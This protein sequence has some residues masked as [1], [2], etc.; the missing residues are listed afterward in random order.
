MG[1]VLH[2]GPE[3]SIVHRFRPRAA[4]WLAVDIDPDHP[5]TDRTMS[6][7][8]LELPDGACSLVLCSHVLDMVEPHD[9]AV[10]ELHRVMLAGRPSDHPG[11][12]AI[13]AR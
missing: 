7:L 12:V 2:V 4:T 13:R 5:L 10:A 3:R 1:D 6:V 9:D 11:A 8:R